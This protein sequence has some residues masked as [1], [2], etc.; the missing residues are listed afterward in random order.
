MISS[1]TLSGSTI[2]F[3]QQHLIQEF[4]FVFHITHFL[5]WLE[6]L[7][8]YFIKLAISLRLFAVT[9]N[10]FNNYFPKY[11]GYIN[12]IKTILRM[13]KTSAVC[14]YNQKYLSNCGII[15]LIGKEQR[16]FNYFFTGNRFPAAAVKLKLRPVILN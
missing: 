11:Q 13:S 6:I 7:I 10:G 9:T 16:A 1:I 8:T 12:F 3:Q 15:K 4:S 2:S 14:F 5:I